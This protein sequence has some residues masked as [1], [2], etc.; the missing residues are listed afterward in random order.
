MTTD[1]PAWTRATWEAGCVTNRDAG[2]LW[3]GRGDP[4]AVG[5]V[6]R[7]ND[8]PKTR[9]TVTGYEVKGGWLMVLGYRTDSPCRAGNLGGAEILWSD[10]Q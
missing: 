6:I 2:T 10:D 4:P 9:V 3:S 1:C 7:C 8:Q 5:A